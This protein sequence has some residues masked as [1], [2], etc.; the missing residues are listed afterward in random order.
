MWARSQTSG[1]RIGSSWRSRSSVEVGDELDRP[2]PDRHEVV[3]ERL[4]DHLHRAD[5][6][7]A[8]AALPHPE[9]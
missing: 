9:R 2:P 8:A 3:D 1:L 4:R 6:N 7:G 5:P